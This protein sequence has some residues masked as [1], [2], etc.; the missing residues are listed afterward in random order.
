MLSGKKVSF[1]LCNT[2]IPSFLI[3]ISTKTLNS[4]SLKYSM[5]ESEQKIQGAHQVSWFYTFKLSILFIFH[6]IYDGDFVCS[7]YTYSTYKKLNRKSTVW[8]CI[9][10]SSETPYVGLCHHLQTWLLSCI[11]IGGMIGNTIAVIGQFLLKRLLFN[12]LLLYF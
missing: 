5:N 2:F 8:P 6:L 10:I 4:Q 7:N 3:H 12:L 1:R 9:F 11:A